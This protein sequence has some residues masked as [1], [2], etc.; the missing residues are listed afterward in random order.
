[1]LWSQVLNSR[2]LTK[3]MKFKMSCFFHLLS[4]SYKGLS[5]GLITSQQWFTCCWWFTVIYSV[6]YCILGASHSQDC[7]ICESLCCLQLHHHSFCHKRAVT[8]QSVSS[9]WPSGTSKQLSFT[10]MQYVH[11]C[12]VLCLPRKY[13]LKWF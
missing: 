6:Y 11:F 4:I 2:H 3:S 1:M 10:G 13:F 8:T 9:V 7:S 12:H 5:G